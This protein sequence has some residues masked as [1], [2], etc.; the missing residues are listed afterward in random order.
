MFIYQFIWNIHNLAIM[1]SKGS[2]FG[3]ADSLQFI[4]FKEHISKLVLLSRRAARVMI[5]PI[6]GSDSIYDRGS[7]SCRRVAAFGIYKKNSLNSTVVFG[8]HF[9]ENFMVSY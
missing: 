3:Q 2:G 5:Q 8:F 4:P 1:D 9:L 7:S 6:A